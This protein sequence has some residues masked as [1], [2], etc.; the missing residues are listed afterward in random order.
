MLGYL[1]YV[2]DSCSSKWGNV[3]FNK[4]TNLFRLMNL[5]HQDP[6]EKVHDHLVPWLLWRMWKN[7]N[8]FRFKRTDYSAPNAVSKAWENIENG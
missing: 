5:K 8:D 1:G 4:S 3:R 7:R 6:T 2:S